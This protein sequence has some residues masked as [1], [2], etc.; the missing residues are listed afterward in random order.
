MKKIIGILGGMG[1]EATAQIYTLILKNTK[2]EKDQDHIEVLIYSNPKI[3]PRTDAILGKG[4][5]PT[6]DLINGIKILLNGGADFIIIPCITAH[7]F[8]PG[9]KKQIDFS[10]LS[11]IEESLKWVKNNVPNLRKAG[12]LSSTGTLASRLFHDHFLSGG[13]EVIHPDEKEQ[14]QV[15]NAIF[16]DQGIKAGHSSGYA[17]NTILSMAENLI[18]RGA[19]AIIAGCTEIPL[20]LT[21]RDISVPLIEPMEITARAGIIEAGYNL[22]EQR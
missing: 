19:E 16:G 11:L 15:M 14:E 22:S 8:L 18:N 5:D 10:Y 17:R 12:I 1:P 9:I 7:Y 2:A 21:A 3:P 4:P 20:A 6:I 13:I